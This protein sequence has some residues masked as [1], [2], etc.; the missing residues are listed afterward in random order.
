MHNV[1]G[2]IRRIMGNVEVAY[3]DSHVDGYVRLEG[4]LNLVGQ[5]VLPRVQLRK[6]LQLK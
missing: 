4:H 6:K 1:G 5:P 2:Q 3:E